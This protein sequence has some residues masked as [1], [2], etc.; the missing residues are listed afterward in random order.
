MAAEQ[1]ERLAVGRDLRDQDGRLPPAGVDVGVH[2]HA[3]RLAGAAAGAQRSAVGRG[4]GDDRHGRQQ[5]GATVV[6]AAPHRRDAHVVQVLVRAHVQ[7]GQHP[8]TAR[9]ER[10]LGAGHA[11]DQHDAPGD[12]HTLVVAG[13][14]LAHV[15]ELAGHG[16][17]RRERMRERA[18]RAAAGLHPGPH[19]QADVSRV[20]YELGGVAVAVEHRA[21]VLQAG[22]LAL[23]ARMLGPARQRLDMRR[24]ALA[25]HVTHRRPPRSARPVR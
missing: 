18:Q 11:V 2:S 3:R 8:V 12:V 19:G 6:G 4:D 20:D 21:H 14:A 22:E 16:A 23:G 17:R 25:R 24:Q 1:H 10:L 5:R 9:L 13:R 15:D 7:L